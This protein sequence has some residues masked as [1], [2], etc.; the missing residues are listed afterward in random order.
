MLRSLGLGGFGSWAMRTPRGGGG[1]GAMQHSGHAGQHD[2]LAA[3]YQAVEVENQQ[4]FLSCTRKGDGLVLR[5]HNMQHQVPI[6]RPCNLHLHFLHIL[7]GKLTLDTFPHH[8]LV[9]HSF[10]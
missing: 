5:V 2:V 8:V 7:F 1:E 10:C 9:S 3:M 6:F 4:E